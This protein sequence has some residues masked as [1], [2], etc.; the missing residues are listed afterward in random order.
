MTAGRQLWNDEQ[1]DMRRGL[2]A[3]HNPVTV[4]ELAFDE[5]VEVLMAYVR[6]GPVDESRSALV[7]F[8]GARPSYRTRVPKTCTACKVH[9]PTSLSMACILGLGVRN[10]VAADA[11]PHFL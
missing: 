9:R 5:L 11:A 7:R 10:K 1:T 2:R 4:T 8:K 6:N 3:L